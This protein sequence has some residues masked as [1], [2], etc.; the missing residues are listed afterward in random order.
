MP[1][2]ACN[3]IATLIYRLLEQKN[4]RDISQISDHK[5]YFINISLSTFTLYVCYVSAIDYLIAQ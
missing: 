4:I 3:V 1:K 2:V 5:N